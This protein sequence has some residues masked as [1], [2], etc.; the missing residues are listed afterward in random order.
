MTN[1]PSTFQHK[2]VAVQSKIK[3]LKENTNKFG[4]Y[5]YRSC[6]DILHAVKPLL[7]DYN[8]TLTLSDEIKLI[9]DR[10]YVV[11]QAVISD[12][13]KK[14]GN[15][16]YAREAHDQKG[17]SEAQ[18]TGS[19]SSYARKYAL[20]GLLGLDDER[21]PDTQPPK[22]PQPRQDQPKPTGTEFPATEAQVKLID[23]LCKKLGERNPGVTTSRQA[24][25]QIQRLKA[26]EAKLPR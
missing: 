5:N 23:S 2:I 9:G 10:Y 20:A 7:A 19:S 1:D 16:A 25:E 12:G 17:M 21:D 4:G 15:Q 22:E 24:S 11:A 26:L 8:L 6:E 13:E 3:V 18:L 14:F